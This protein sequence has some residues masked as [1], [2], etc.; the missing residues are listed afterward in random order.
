MPRDPIA[1]ARSEWVPDT[2]AQAYLD[3]QLRVDVATALEPD[4]R[5][6]TRS[7]GDGRL[8]AYVGTIPGV[9][10]HLSIAHKRYN[11]R[12]GWHPGR[13]PTWDEIADARDRLLPA[14]RAF[15]MELPK[16]ENYV[17]EH[18]TTFHLHEQMADG[19]TRWADGSRWFVEVMETEGGKL[20]VTDDGYPIARLTP[21]AA[22][23]T[24]PAPAEGGED[25]VKDPPDLDD[26]GPRGFE[27]IDTD[28]PLREEPF[29]PPPATDTG[30]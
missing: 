21:Y 30:T 23:P 11:K 1:K 28:R 25:D 18:L 22:P 13:Y 26:P 4:I 15:V 17:A 19:V 24:P 10:I 14:D 8:D 5:A 16:P 3:S 7:V 6:W 20:A 12:D 2:N 9:G 29:A 27:R